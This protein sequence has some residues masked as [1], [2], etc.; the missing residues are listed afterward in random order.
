MFSSSRFGGIFYFKTMPS[1]QKKQQLKK[2]EEQLSEAKSAALVQ[3]QGLTADE[4][5]DLRANVKKTGGSM[6]V[7]KNTLITLALEKI[8]I[9]LPEKLVGPTALALGLEDEIAPLKEIQKVNS[10]KE[11][12]EFK[13]GVYKQKLLSTD[14][15][16]TLL[17]LPSHTQLIANFIGGLKNPLTRL[18]YAFGYNQTRLVL[19]LKAISEK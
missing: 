6:E 5:S 16:K 14:Q 4:I 1:T 8:G 18:A 13:Y 17:S 7:F 2:I 11:K 10:D 9:K 12:T 3:Y 15:L 19:A